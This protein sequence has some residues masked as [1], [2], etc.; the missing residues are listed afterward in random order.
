[1]WLP[2]EH[3]IA[4]SGEDGWVR[5]LDIESSSS[6]KLAMHDGRSYKLAVHPEIPHVI[7]SAGTDSKVLSIDI[8]EREPTE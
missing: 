2:L 5:L 7:F 3:F 8:R 4:I 6:K 1:M